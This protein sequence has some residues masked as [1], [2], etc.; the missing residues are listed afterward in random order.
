MYSDISPGSELALY[1][2]VGSTTVP[3]AEALHQ[4]SL[5]EPIGPEDYFAGP[6]APR[7]LPGAAVFDYDRDGDL[8]LY[9]TNGSGAANSLFQNQ[10]E[11]TGSLEFVDVGTTAGVDA[12]DQDSFGACFGDLDND[13]DLD[14]L[15][16]GRSE[17][18]RLFENLGDG[19]FTHVADDV[20]AGG[21]LSSASCSM[22]DIDND[23]LLD[24]VV[25]NSFDQADAFAIAIEP[26]ALNHPNQLLHNQGDLTF[27][28]VSESSGIL[29]NQGYPPG[30][31]GISWAVGAADVDHD[32]DA[33]IVI[34]DDQAAIPPTR[35]GG[36]DRAYIHVFLNDGRGHFTDHALIQNAF[37]ASEWMGISFGDLNCDG[38]LDLFASSFGDYGHPTVG[39]PYFK[40]GTA[41]RPFF[42]T[43][44]GTFVDSGRSIPDGEGGLTTT[45]PATA[46]GWGTAIFDADNDGDNDILYHGGIDLFGLIVLA[47]NPGVLLLNQGQCSGTFMQD[48]NAIT[49]DHLTRNVRGLAV[50]DLDGNGFVDVVT[51]ANLMTPPEL[52]LLPS[53]VSYGDP[54]D[55][56]AFIV[57]IMRLV[58]G[59]GEPPAYVWNGFENGL[60]DLKV[61]IASDNGNHH[62]TVE[63]MGS[64]GLTSS[65]TVNRDGIGAMISFTPKDGVTSIQAVV[66]GSS[67]SSQHALRKVFGL[68][69]ANKGTLDIL[70]PGGV[71]NR[72]YNIHEGSHVVLPE[73]PCSY[74]EDWPRKS[75]YVACVRQALSDLRAQGAI[76][77][78]LSG[79]LLSS[80]VRA[81]A[82]HGH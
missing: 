61:E 62:V 1:A 59:P 67:H 78:R 74:D 11:Q 45:N 38:N 79:Q 57:P 77:N 82:E 63:L 8:D 32:G 81:Y 24:I 3:E 70:W 54:L 47:D 71:K 64:V 19:T 42:G 20:V 30:A 37:S 50:G 13:G 35:Q 9:I 53:P 52:P 26:Y 17:A 68:G 56:T 21:D 55:A 31:A 34:L 10:L 46:F 18:N 65:G 49:A 75:D 60:G 28:D 27:A 44:D 76:D 14:L 66:G 29:E 15:V 16:L 73:I 7:G 23:G 72:L 69:A 2:R 36:A 22:L 80:A 12:A 48:Q 40:G 39:D 43:G 25:V 5:I 6:M 41:S 33:D 4:Q 58:N 51:V